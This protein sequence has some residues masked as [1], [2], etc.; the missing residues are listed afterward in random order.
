MRRLTV[1]AN[2]S[3]PE[4]V[5]PFLERLPLELA[6]D[7]GMYQGNDAHY[8][9]CGASALNVILS[10]LSLARAPAP[11]ALLDFG[12]GAGRVTR[13]LRSAFPEADLH[14]CDLREQDVRFNDGVLGV[15]AWRA[16]TD[17]SMLRAPRPYDLIWVGSVATHLP[18]ERAEQ[19]LDKMLSWTTPGGIV[20][21]SLH[22]RYVHR[23]QCDASCRYIHDEG[24]QEI[25]REYHA[26]GYGYADYLNQPGYGIS[27]TKL[28]WVGALIE[29]RP[30][31]RLICLTEQAWDDHHD[32]LAVQNR[33]ISTLHGGA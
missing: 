22:G 18:A 23:R 24:W 16:G 19:L 20:V 13:W 11:A 27:L 33:P 29:R 17:L 15:R 12:A 10:V 1:S 3:L 28:S 9:T 32:V 5:A 30:G 8:L 26:T 14:T 31:V 25:A 2:L 6:D 7:D 21:M 4:T